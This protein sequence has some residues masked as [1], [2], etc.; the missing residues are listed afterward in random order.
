MRLLISLPLHR[1]HP[2]LIK[3][4]IMHSRL[5]SLRIPR[6][7]R[8]SPTLSSI[9]S[10]L[11]TIG[12]NNRWPLLLPAFSISISVNRGDLAVHVFDEIDSGAGI[13]AAVAAN[14]AEGEDT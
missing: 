3:R 1:I 11:P 2:W 9:P 12:K 6:H 8:H 14:D 7:P 5:S 10:Q 13:D 4:R